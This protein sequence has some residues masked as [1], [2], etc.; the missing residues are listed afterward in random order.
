VQ[1]SRGGGGRVYLADDGPHR[2][3]RLSA[4]QRHK[5]RAK[6]VGFAV[7]VTGEGLDGGGGVR[8]SRGSSFRSSATGWLTR[9]SIAAGAG[10]TLRL[11]FDEALGKEP[12]LEERLHAAWAKS[13]AKLDWL[14][15]KYQRS[16][17]SS[18]KSRLSANISRPA[19]RALTRRLRSGVKAAMCSGRLSA[20]SRRRTGAQKASPTSVYKQAGPANDPHFGLL[21]QQKGRAR[22]ALQVDSASRSPS[23]VKALVQWTLTVDLFWGLANCERRKICAD[24]EAKRLAPA[25]STPLLRAG[26]QAAT[27]IIVIFD[28]TAAMYVDPEADRRQQQQRRRQRCVSVRALS[29]VEGSSRGG[30]LAI[31]ETSDGRAR[32]LESRGAEGRRP[33]VDLTAVSIITTCYM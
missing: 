4:L 29:G 14:R 8:V 25:A 5:Q 15:T 16:S 30:E 13:R 27:S 2:P 24:A 19:A 21:P 33:A 11:E 9:A 23:Q 1:G 6:V 18:R 28:G 17:R 26:P 7:P 3:L 32:V 20:G 31:A 12:T 10:E 22:F